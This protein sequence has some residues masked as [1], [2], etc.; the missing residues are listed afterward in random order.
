MIH[1][2]AVVSSDAKIAANVK[3]G[4]YCVIGEGVELAENVELKSHVVIEGTHGGTYIGAGTKIYSFAVIGQIS[5]DM[6]YYH[7]EEATGLTIGKN[8]II[9]EHVTIHMGTPASEGTLVGDNNLFM[10]GVHI[11]HDCVV[12]NNI[13]IANNVPLAG[14]VEVDD[15]AIIGGNSAVQQFVKIGKYAIVGGMTGVDQDVLPYGLVTG[16]RPMYWEGLNLIGLRRKGFSN[17]QIDTIKEAYKIL[18][19]DELFVNRM[20]TLEMLAEDSAE[21]KEIVNAVKNRSKHSFTKPKQ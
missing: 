18:F 5:Q 16:N 13:Y 20:A 19:S 7:S 10:V 12:G 15:Y 21:I 3:V 9:R 11:A 8:N 14:E 17:S 4:P 2:T 1:P 6:K